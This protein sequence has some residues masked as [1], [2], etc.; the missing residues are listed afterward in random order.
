MEKLSTTQLFVK[1]LLESFSN[2]FLSECDQ[3]VTKYINQVVLKLTNVDLFGSE[4][5][6]RTADPRLMSPVRQPLPSP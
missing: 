1:K 2:Y 6:I 5:R 4:R 3:F